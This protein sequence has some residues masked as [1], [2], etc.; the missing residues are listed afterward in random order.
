VSGLNGSKRVLVTG[1]AGMLGS[2]VLLSAP[3]GV[4]TIGTDLVDAAGVDEMGVD[5]SDE[6][7]VNELF[8]RVGDISGVI[9][10]AAYTAVDKA[11]GD[12]ALAL[13]V[14]GDVCGVL[15]R[16]AKA[17]GVPQVLVG[18]DFVFDGERGEAYS[19]DDEPNP[20]SAYGR[21]KLA[22]ERAALEVYPDGTRIVRTQWLY[23]PRGQHFPG[24]M[25]SLAKDRDQLRV[26]DDQTGSPT[27][28]LEL[29]PALWDVLELGREAIY[30]AACEGSCT[31]YGLACATLEEAG[32]HGVNI[33]P[34]STEEFPRPARRPPHSVLNCGRLT[35][36][37]GRS[38]E[39][40]REALRTFLGSE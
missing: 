2:Q 28:T 4:K 5:L 14:N 37:R 35:E 23:G 13:R 32:V 34:C 22:G 33:E 17:A 19:E 18:T 6:R 8:E 40:W 25:L 27:S 11:E 24:T 9:H 36:L 38:L 26:V 10:T 29:A 30:H 39:P 21:T 15:S 20:V 1:A 31:W 16:V 12:E 3:D 7:A